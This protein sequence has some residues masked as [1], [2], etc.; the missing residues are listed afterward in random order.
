MNTTFSFNFGYHQKR[1]IHR[2]FV[3]VS[4]NTVIQKSKT[5][6]GFVFEISFYTFLPQNPLLNTKLWSMFRS[7][8]LMTTFQADSFVEILFTFVQSSAARLDPWEDFVKSSLLTFHI[9]FFFYY[10]FF[11]CLCITSFFWFSCLFFFYP[12]WGIVLLY[13]RNPFKIHLE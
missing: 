9:F 12:I 10:L 1:E 7:K 6:W 8:W 4:L 3:K 2:F 11:P 13:I 5:M